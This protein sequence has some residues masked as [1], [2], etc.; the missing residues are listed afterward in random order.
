MPHVLT[1]A[2]FDEEMP[3][4]EI[5]QTRTVL[6]PIVPGHRAAR[7]EFGASEEIAELLK[8]SAVLE[9]DAQQA[10]DD[11]VQT[12]QLGGAVGAFQAEKD[13]SGVRI[14]MN[15]DVESPL[16]RNAEFLRAVTTAGRKRTTRRGVSYIG[17]AVC[18]SL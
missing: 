1:A 14:V 3:A 15:A 12:D 7:L 9:G 17:H 5:G 10:G 8:G 18:N 16:T 2:V 13:F 11:V 6:Q 4:D